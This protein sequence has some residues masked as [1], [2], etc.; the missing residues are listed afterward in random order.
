M[1]RV[2]IRP[3]GQQVLEDSFVLFEYY[4]CVTLTGHSRLAQAQLFSLVLDISLDEVLPVNYTLTSVHQLIDNP[5]IV[6]H[7]L[8]RIVYFLSLPVGIDTR[9]HW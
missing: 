3:D 4:R 7:V 9:D 5:F 6:G 2:R 1:N 8:L